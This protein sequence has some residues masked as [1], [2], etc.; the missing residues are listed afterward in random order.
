MSPVKSPVGPWG[1]EVVSTA[2]IDT[3]FFYQRRSR[4]YFNRL[5]RKNNQDLRCGLGE[6]PDGVGKE[7]KLGMLISGIWK[8]GSKW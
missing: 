1:G 7:R 8:V 5:P 2:I 6:G 4:C 3:D